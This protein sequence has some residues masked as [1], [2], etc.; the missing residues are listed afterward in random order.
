MSW[1]D[2]VEHE[3]KLK[4]ALNTFNW[5]VPETICTEVTNRIRTERDL[6]PGPLPK[7]SCSRYDGSGALRL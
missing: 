3:S 7:G 2:V 1:N 5:P 4:E 6:I